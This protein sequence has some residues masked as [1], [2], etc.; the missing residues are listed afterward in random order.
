MEDSITALS[1]DSAPVDTADEEL[2]TAVNER[3]RPRTGGGEGY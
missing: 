3:P 1:A 2:H